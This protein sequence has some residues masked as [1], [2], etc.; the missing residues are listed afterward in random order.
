MDFYT[1]MLRDIAFSIAQDFAK[2]TGGG[3]ALHYKIHRNQPD[4]IKTLFDIM[5][6]KFGELGVYKFCQ[7][8]KIPCTKPDLKEYAIHQKNFDPDFVC[9]NLPVHCKTQDINQSKSLTNGSPSWT[10]QFSG[11]GKDKEIFD[12]KGEQ[13]IVLCQKDVNK[14]HI[15]GFLE[16][17]F[18]H[19]NS[20]FK[21]PI[22]DR[23]KS[24]KKVVYYDDLK[25]F[26]KEDRFR[27]LSKHTNLL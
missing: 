24:I 2:R 18:L 13:Y 27:F 1:I 5:V 6:G 15:Y 4:M 16:V 8:N 10:F 9:H 26:S 19:H 3:N 11:G 21:L 20:L 23:L 14:I 7:M 25:K 12:N 22:I 17:N